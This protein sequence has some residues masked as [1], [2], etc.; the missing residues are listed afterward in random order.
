MLVK[1]S[2]KRDI[3]DA[4]NSVMEQETDRDKSI[5]IIAGKLAD[6]IIN[7]IKSATIDYVTGL[8]SPSGPVTGTFQSIIK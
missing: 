1:E 7:A 4:F 8:V 3:V 6:S 5:D 2:I